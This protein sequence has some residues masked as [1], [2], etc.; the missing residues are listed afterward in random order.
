M[1]PFDPV[2]TTSTALAHLAAALAPAGGP[3]AA[4]V[5]LTVLVRLALHPFT[6]AA[7]RGER[8]RLRLAPR[9]ADIRRRHAGNLGTM[10]A[11]LSALYRSEGISP[12]AGVLP[13]LAQ[14]PIFLVLF[15]A[16]R[17]PHGP[18]AAARLF[19]V[20]L[21][22]HAFTAAGV[23]HV[24]VY[25]GLFA[26]VVALARVNSRRAAMIMRIN[27]AAAASDPNAASTGPAPGVEAAM[28]RI[29]RALPY[30][31]L[32]SAAVLPLATA[33]YLVTTTAWSTA[34]NAALRRGLL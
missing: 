26:V 4:V 7:V 8:A 31:L 10:S 20:P 17:D 1:P 25:A 9:V 19:G 21:S 16:F 15:A 14:V 22:T 2:A 27:A 12:V 24:A 3:V 33:I 23:A 11:E 34:E 29:G 6:R 28:G 13:M 18:L 30:A 32:V 5:V